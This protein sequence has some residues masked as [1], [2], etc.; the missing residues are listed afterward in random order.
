MEACRVQP[1]GLC[2][3]LVKHIL[4]LSMSLLNQYILHWVS[5]REPLQDH[6]PTNLG[7]LYEM[8]LTFIHSDYT[9]SCS[10]QQ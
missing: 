10:L 9:L 3:H 2:S 6:K 4:D 7:Q 1:L 5:L 8:L